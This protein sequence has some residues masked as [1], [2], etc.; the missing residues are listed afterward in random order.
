M[1]TQAATPANDHK[2]RQAQTAL[3]ELLAAVLQKGFYGSIALEVA[4]QDGTIQSIR[5]RTER[6]E[7]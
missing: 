5:R 2:T 6:M 7:R 4:V 3:R 1:I